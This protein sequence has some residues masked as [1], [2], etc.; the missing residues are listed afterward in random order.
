MIRTSLEVVSQYQ[1][2]SGIKDVWRGDSGDTSNL[3]LRLT[4]SGELRAFDMESA[5]LGRLES[6][7][8]AWITPGT[9]NR[10]ILARV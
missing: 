3:V 4:V 5:T 1:A 6:P 10:V 7:T 8:V 9:L 2:E